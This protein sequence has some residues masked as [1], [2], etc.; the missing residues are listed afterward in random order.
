[1]VKSK[2]NGIKEKMLKLQELKLKARKIDIM[3]GGLIVVLNA[4]FAY[5]NGIY[6]GY[7]VRIHSG[8]KSI[9]AIADL[10][11]DMVKPG[12]IGLFHEAAEAL[13]PKE[14]AKIQ[15]RKKIYLDGNKKTTVE[16][17][18]KP[19]QIGLKNYY[20]SEEHTSELQSH[21]FISYAVFCLKKKIKKTKTY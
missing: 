20:R 10:T 14:G 19:K 9:I 18:F 5:Q 17:T 7:R 11:N 3:A 16:I 6:T 4:N 8:K 1:M 12:E 21:S 2:Y 13:N 15:T